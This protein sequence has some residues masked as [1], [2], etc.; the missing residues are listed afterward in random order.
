MRISDWSSDV[1]SS[2]LD[3]TNA[4][5][6][7]RDCR[8][9]CGETLLEMLDGQWKHIL[10]DLILQIEAEHAA[11]VLRTALESVGFGRFDREVACRG[12]ALVRVTHALAASVRFKYQFG[13]ASVASA[14]DPLG[15][16]DGAD[17]EPNFGS[18]L[19]PIVLE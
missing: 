17:A 9:A 3:G 19:A 16:N 8:V 11:K 4:V 7:R 1:C 10:R 2:D 14:D 6:V 18:R 12:N 15:V 13:L 5:I